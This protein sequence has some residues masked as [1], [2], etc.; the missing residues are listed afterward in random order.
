VKDDRV[1]LRDIQERVRRI[2]DFVKD[3]RD[4]FMNSLLIQDAVIRN[5]E[6]IGEAV[7][8][9]SPQIRERNPDVHWKQMAAFRDILI[10]DYMSIILKEVWNTIEKDLPL[11]RLRIPQILAT[12]ER[13]ET[14]DT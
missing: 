9:L 1:Y 3:G 10:H 2:D 7:K 4:V 13:D 12:L 5:F 8:N 6:V 11:L 14:G